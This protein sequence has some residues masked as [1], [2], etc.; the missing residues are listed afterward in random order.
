MNKSYKFLFPFIQAGIISL[1]VL[2]SVYN[3]SCRVSTEGIQLLSGD[4]DSPKI[5]SVCMESDSTI[6]VVFS[7]EVKVDGITVCQAPDD[8]SDSS[9]AFLESSP[10][11]IPLKAE[12]SDSGKQIVCILQNSVQIGRKYILFGRVEDTNGNSLT[13]SSLLTG[14]NS[15]PATVVMSEI[16]DKSTAKGGSEFIE[17]YVLESGNLSGF[18]LYSANDGEDFNFT[19]PAV[20]VC[21]KDVIVVH[22]RKTG[23]DC[24]SEL[25][26]NLSLSTAVGSNNAARDLWAENTENRLGATQDVILLTD[27]NTGCVKD[28]FLYSR[29][30]KTAWAKTDLQDAALKASGCGVWKPD[31]EFENAFMI[32]GSSAQMIFKRKNIAELEQ[33]AENG[34]LSDRVVPADSDDWERITASR[35]TPGG[36]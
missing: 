20:E 27:G 15:H 22:L 16:Q 6:A 32:N 10:Y 5:L 25:S 1:L 4:Y 36:I 13:F 28:A 34:M 23:D 11:G 30:T 8:F 19:L 2:F 24:I 14:F 17:L 21:A 9:L 18:V 26:D 33:M 35:V 7:E 12:I 31:G 3:V 29:T